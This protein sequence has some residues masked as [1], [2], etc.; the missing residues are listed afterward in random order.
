MQKHWCSGS[1]GTPCPSLRPAT[2]HTS[3]WHSST[4]CQMDLGRMQLWC[5][6]LVHL[7]ERDVLQPTCQ[8]CWLTITFAGADH[9]WHGCHTNVS[10]LPFK[11]GALPR[12]N[13]SSRHLWL[14]W[15][16]NEEFFSLSAFREIVLPPLVGG[17]QHISPPLAVGSTER[18]F[19]NMERRIS[20]HTNKCASVGKKKTQTE[21]LLLIKQSL[22]LTLHISFYVQAMMHQPN[23]DKSGGTRVLV[24]PPCGADTSE[25]GS[26][27]PPLF[28]PLI[29]TAAAAAA[30][31]ELSGY[32]WATD[33]KHRTLIYSATNALKKVSV[34][35]AQIERERKKMKLIKIWYTQFD[36]SYR[37]R[38]KQTNWVLFY[39][40]CFSV[41]NSLAEGIIPSRKRKIKKKKRGEKNDQLYN[42]TQTVGMASVKHPCYYGIGNLVS[43]GWVETQTPPLILRLTFFSLPKSGADTD[44]ERQTQWSSDTARLHLLQRDPVTSCLSL[45]LWN[46]WVAWCIW[47]VCDSAACVQVGASFTTPSC[48]FF[49]FYFYI[50]F[51]TDGHVYL[52][53]RWCLPHSHVHG[54]KGTLLQFVH[55]A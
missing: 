17:L 8:S 24:Q 32:F 34:K 25:N 44:R 1:A 14:D 20:R 42:S 52:C 9:F 4:Q 48:M 39:L 31:A 18:K 43:W 7:F 47:H 13:L 28:F 46:F 27:P 23:S 35:V 6:L 3:P 53:I 16:R 50:H 12:G 26:L 29:P 54:T 10:S 15:D 41:I 36:I 33:A 19:G 55:L 49:I 5:A 21:T 38:S 40:I 22:G 30:A 45:F 11:H 37:P 51:F 2:F